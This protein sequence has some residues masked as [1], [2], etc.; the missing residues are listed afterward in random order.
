MDGFDLGG[1]ELLEA[2]IGV[3]PQSR[4]RIQAALCR[5][6]LGE[7][8]V[9]VVGLPRFFRKSEVSHALYRAITLCAPDHCAIRHETGMTLPA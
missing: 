6:H 5:T 4:R 3:R 9:F 1:R 7:E 8:R 2:S